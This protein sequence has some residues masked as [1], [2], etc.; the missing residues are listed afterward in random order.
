MPE[1][2][3]L[4]DIN[5]DLIN[6]YNAVREH[7][8]AVIH[9]LKRL[10]VTKRSFYLIRSS[11]PQSPIE[12]AAR[13]LYLNRTGFGGMYRLNLRGE[14]NVPYG[15]GGRTPQ[16]LCESDMLLRASSAL[17]RATI[18]HSD[19]ESQIDTVGEG[20]VVYCDPTYTVAHDRNGFVRYNE[21][22][23]SWADQG[24]LARCAQRARDRGALVIVTNA[25]HKSIEELYPQSHFCQ[26]ERLSLV[27]TDPL[28]RRAVQEYLI[29]V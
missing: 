3:E 28:K 20:D 22:N 7:H 27:S 24:R 25:H 2:S 1:K 4:S 6:T 15:G 10:R 12:R 5:E 11:E 18:K 8:V 23:F 16:T 29:I 13:F 26:L 14:F 19:F 17:K 9:A 21:R